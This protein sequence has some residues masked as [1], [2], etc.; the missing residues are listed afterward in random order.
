MTDYAPYDVCCHRLDAPIHQPGYPDHRYWKLYADHETK[1]ETPSCD[2]E[3][4]RR[5]VHME[6][7]AVQD[8]GWRL[9]R[10]YSFDSRY[11]LVRR[12]GMVV[13]MEG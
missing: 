2:K 13:R 6:L 11:I 9:V 5:D 3:Q 8:P 12:Q 7:V 1:L 10:V 4:W